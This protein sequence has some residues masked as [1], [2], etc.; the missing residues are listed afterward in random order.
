MRSA[1]FVALCLIETV[2]LLCATGHTD[3]DIVNNPR[4]VIHSARAA[5]AGDTA[6]SR[7]M[8]SSATGQAPARLEVNLGPVSLDHYTWVN[9]NEVK[10]CPS[11]LTPAVTMAS[12][13]GPYRR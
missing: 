9:Q 7:R 1:R 4:E 10:R 5:V 11:G 2:A 3:G 6:S 13:F 8:S 12:C